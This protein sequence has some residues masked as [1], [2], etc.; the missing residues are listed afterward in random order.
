[1]P[2]FG[3]EEARRYFAGQA[4]AGAGWWVA[5][6]ASPRVRDATLGD[7][8]P[9]WL[10]P[11][12]LALFVGGSALAAALGSRLWGWVALGWTA[13]VTVGLVGFALVTRDAGWG[14]VAMVA[15]LAGTGAATLTLARGRLPGHWITVGPF[16]FRP[17]PRR[18]P[19]S[20]LRRS[21]Q[22]LVVF[23]MGFFV[24]VPLV[25]TAIEDRLRTRWS[26]LDAPVVGAVG[27]ALL[28]V[29]SGVG[30]W[31]CGVMALRGAGTPLPASTARHLV[32]AGPYR[33]VRNPMAVAGAAQTIG[34]GLLLGS[35]LVV[36]V[37]VAGAVVWDTL[38]RPEEEH[39]MATR[40]G[41]GY[42][43]YRAEVR[44]W[45]PRLSEPD[46]PPATSSTP[47]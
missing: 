24:V 32:V 42:D 26:A 41:P 14:A 7:L 22:Q 3:V 21:L 34:V 46:L 33:R 12:D 1:M 19:R 38:I 36:A 27:L 47:P 37:A 9:A 35:W 23:W 2:R 28:V 6:A 44:C 45:I 39:D 18:D 29:F 8:S 31:S 15:A 10:A 40:F 16:A 20:H 13:L 43:R 17:A 4:V 11:P 30:I 5:V 25:L